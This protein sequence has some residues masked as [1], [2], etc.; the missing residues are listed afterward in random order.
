MIEFWSGL[1]DTQRLSV[2]ITPTPPFVSHP[3]HGAASPCHSWLGVRT[4]LLS[5]AIY[6]FF[7]IDWKNSHRGGG[8]NMPDGPSRVTMLVIVKLVYLI[9][10]VY[11]PLE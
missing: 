11:V 1:E 3:P 4:T 9:P 5:F 6:L 7:P 8:K 10:G 2:Q